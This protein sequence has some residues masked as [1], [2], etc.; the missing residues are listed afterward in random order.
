[1]LVSEVVSTQAAMQVTSTGSQTFYLMGQRGTDSDTVYRWQ[2]NL[3]AVYFP[4][5]Y[6]T[7]E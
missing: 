7:V 4:V 6:G 2:C 1:M 5:A 3:T